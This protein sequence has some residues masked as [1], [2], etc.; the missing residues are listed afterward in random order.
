MRT[1][2]R[3]LV[4][5]LSVVS[6]L[7]LA[8]P[9]AGAASQVQISNQRRISFN[10]GWRFLK[11][12][13]E[14]AEQPGFDDSKWIELRLP[15]ALPYLFSAYK[16]ATTLSVI[17][18]VVAEWVG[19]DR[20]LGHVIILANANFDMPTLAAAVVVLAAIGIGL[21][22]LVDALERRL[23]FWHE[24]VLTTEVYR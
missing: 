19:A 9:S 14:G 15:H 17:G 12:E 2:I 6:C 16:V 3:T 21:Y 5:W 11:G 7:L 23:L 24:S 1:T 10:D 20:G 4:W 8:L 13:A 22:L 18:A